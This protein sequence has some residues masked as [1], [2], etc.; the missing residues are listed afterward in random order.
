VIDLRMPDARADVDTARLMVVHHGEREVGLLVRD[1]VALLPANSGERMRFT[2]PGGKAMHMIT[3]GL[4]NER[5][6]YQVLDVEALPY[7]AA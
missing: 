1:V 3:V 6:S 5:K 7:L 2:M 4:A